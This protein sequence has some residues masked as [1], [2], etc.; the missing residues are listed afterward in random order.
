MR[1]DKDRLTRYFHLP[2]R[3]AA[4]SIGVS[5]TVLKNACRRQGIKAWPYRKAKI[6]LSN[7]EKR[8]TMD[9]DV[10]LAMQQIVPAEQAVAQSCDAELACDSDGS[11]IPVAAGAVGPGGDG[12]LT[13]W[14]PQV[15][16]TAIPS[17]V[18]D[19]EIEYDPMWPQF[20][21]LDADV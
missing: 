21:T 12:D 1:I 5:T 17:F 10:T 20:D 13:E 11:G 8:S 9:T 2:L 18:V 7:E 4:E 16:P 3:Q 14:V 19:I 15:F 6:A